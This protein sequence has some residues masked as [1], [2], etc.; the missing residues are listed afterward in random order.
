MNDLELFGKLPKAAEELGKSAVKM[1][2]ASAE[3]AS[4]ILKLK[5][6]G[7]ANLEAS[8]RL[9]EII[10]ELKDRAAKREGKGGEQK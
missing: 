2:E 6:A 1:S 7:K 10:E 9:R 8:T 5:D 3:I 4:A